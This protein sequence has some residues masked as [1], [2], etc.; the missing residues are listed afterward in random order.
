[1]AEQQSLKRNVAL[2]V[3]KPELARDRSYVERFHREA[4]SAAALVQANI[5]QIYEVGE[6]EGLHFIAQEYVRGRNLRQYLARHGAVEPFMAVNVLRQVTLA[7][8]KSGEQGVIHRD[9]KPENI[10]LSTSGEV[11]VTDFGLARVNNES[12]SHDLTQIGI[13]MGTPLYMSPEQINSGRVD[14]RS[15]IYSLGVTIYHMLAGHPPF[16]GE[17]ALAIAVQHVHQQPV[18]LDQLRPDVPVELSDLILKM[19][20]KDPDDRPMN[21]TQLLREIK[22]IKIEL[23]DS[24]ETLVEKLA[25]DEMSGTAVST[26]PDVS[27]LAVTRQLQSVMK[28]HVRSWWTSPATIALFSLLTLA[29][30]GTGVALALRNPPRDPLDV[31]A[32]M[33]AKIPRQ[34]TIMEQYWAACYGQTEEWWYAVLEYFPPELA[35]P[36]SQHETWLFHYRAKE[37][38]G[39]L[40][41][42]DGNWQ[43]ALSIYKELEGAEDVSPSFRVIGLAGQ[44]IA[45][46]H[47]NE[48]E[49]SRRL[50]MEIIV[51]LNDLNEFMRSRVEEL[52][53][54]F[55]PQFSSSFTGLMSASGAG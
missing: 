9:I 26:Q 5:V 28:G 44:A 24:W 42:T 3:L 10:M 17:T 38:L 37:R 4:Q 29:A 52:L 33:F 18:A 15:D 14:P 54:Q 11:K 1:L 2:K 41:L 36:E 32:E 49:L 23:D 34:D 13:T 47:L 21:A 45:N 6:L 12:S 51:E 53:Q 40:F 39:E 31:G 43:K 50:L 25:L 7:L 55:E 35:P 27:K 8:Q 22:K 48:P 20:A 30:A 16:E 19:I 46:Y